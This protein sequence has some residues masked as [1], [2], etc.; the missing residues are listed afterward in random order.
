M[1]KRPTI[2]D[3]A[4]LAE[5]S[6]STVSHVLNSTRNVEEA[7]RQRVLA[8]IAELGYRPSAAAAAH[9]QAHQKW[10]W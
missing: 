2:S 8:A 1:T 5:V 3:V 10:A 7:T 9:H 4:R 6:K